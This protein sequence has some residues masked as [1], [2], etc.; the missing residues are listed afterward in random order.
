MKKCGDGNLGTDIGEYGL[1]IVNLG[2]YLCG[3]VK[4]FCIFHCWILCNDIMQTDLDTIHRLKYKIS[5][6]Q[7]LQ[8]LTTKILLSTSCWWQ[9]GNI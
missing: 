2:M 7:V 9:W 1:G 6:A 4:L 5:I 3:K 8:K